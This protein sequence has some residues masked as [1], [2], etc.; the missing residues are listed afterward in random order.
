MLRRSYLLIPILLSVLFSLSHSA[1]AEE[2]RFTVRGVIQELYPDGKTAKIKHE[3]IPNYMPAMTMD[4]ETKGTN[5]LRGL[6]KGDVVSF[7]MVITDTEGWIEKVQKVNTA[8]QVPSRPLIRVARDVQP[9]KPGDVM[10]DYTFTNEFGKA[11]KLSDYKGKSLAI[12]FIFT[13]CPFPNF[14]PRMSNNFYD[15]QQ[16]M[17]SNTNNPTNWQL[18]T[19]SFDPEHDSPEVLKDYAKRY[20]Y[21]PAH[22]SFLTGELIDITAITEQFGQQFWT[23]LEAGGINHNLRTAIIDAT[24]HVRT[25]F[26]G[27]TWT[28]QDIAGELVQG[29]KA[30]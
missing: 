24:G 30:K 20:K 22:W 3:A 23:D 19:I 4:L 2:K 6:A 28:P 15:V 11:I 14:C 5:E 12:T 25:I 8:P 18:L 29:A 9:L 7:L 13:R 27:N 10:P 16:L 1:L 17:L 21:D 26:P